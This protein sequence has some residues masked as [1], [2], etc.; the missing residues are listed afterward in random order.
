M[1]ERLGVPEMR[2]RLGAYWSESLSKG[3]ALSVQLEIGDRIKGRVS[4]TVT[5]IP[6]ASIAILA[7]LYADVLPRII[8]LTQDASAE[9]VRKSHGSDRPPSAEDIAL[10]EALLLHFRSTDESLE[11][12]DVT[13]LIESALRPVDELDDDDD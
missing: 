10:K 1:T 4:T 11:P 12:P 13:R 2:E 3:L 6:D 5:A 9:L 7:Q 8:L